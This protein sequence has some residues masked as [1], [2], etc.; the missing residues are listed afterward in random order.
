MVGRQDL[1][2]QALSFSLFIISGDSGKR[3]ARAEK[4]QA[5]AGK[6]K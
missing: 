5:E 2:L 1:L 3:R 6:E 4:A